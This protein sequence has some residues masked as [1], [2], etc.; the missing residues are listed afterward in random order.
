MMIIIIIIIIQFNGYLLTCRLNSTHANYKASTKTRI[1]QKNS[2]NTQDKTLKK[3]NKI[4]YV[5]KQ[6]KISTGAE[7]QYPDKT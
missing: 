7:I 6:Y 3:Q 5:V 1:K 4:I 2:R